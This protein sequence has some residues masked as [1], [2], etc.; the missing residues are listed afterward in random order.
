MT[1]SLNEKKDHRA[2]ALSRRA[3]YQVKMIKKEVTVEWLV[4]WTEIYRKD[5]DFSA[6]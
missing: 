1:V 3:N 5:D 2:N 4:G 6:I